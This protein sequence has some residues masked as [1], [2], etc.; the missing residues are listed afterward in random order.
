M[1][2]SVEQIKERLGIAEVLGSYLKLQKAGANYKA[3]CPFHS[4]KTPSFHISPS[5]NS[6]Y[7]FGCGEKGDIFSFVQKF[8]GL[9]FKGALRLLGERA[10]IP[11]VFEREESRGE[12]EKLY[13]LLETAALFFERNLTEESA[14]YLKGRGLSDE[15]IRLWRI[16]YAT[17][18]WRALLFHVRKLGYSDMEIEKAGL[19]KRPDDA[20]GKDIYDRFRGRIMFPIADQ[21]GRVI[22]F[23][24]R[25]FPDD[26][27]AKAS[28]P[29]NEGE[30]AR[31]TAPGEQFRAAKYINSPE[32]EL[33]VKS[34]ILYGFDKAKGHIRKAN[35]SILVEG[36][37]DLVLAHQAGFKNTIALSGT[38]LSGEHLA[39]LSRLSKRMVI[40]LDADSA[41]IASAGKGARIALAE[42]FDIKVAKLP[43]GLDPADAIAK[44]PEIFRGAVR[45]AKHIIDFYLEILK[46]RIDDARK[47]RL[48]VERVVLPFVAQIQSAIDQAHFVARVAEVLSIGEEPVWTEVRKLRT[49]DTS[50]K[51][52][53]PEETSRAQKG[54]RETLAERLFGLL[55]WQENAEKPLIEVEPLRKS[56]EELL[57]D[58]FTFLKDVFEKE[59]ERAVFAAEEFF[60]DADIEA[61]SKELVV[62]LEEENLKEELLAL[63]VSLREAEKKKDE[64]EVLALSKRHND[65]SRK[66]HLLRASS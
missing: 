44:D 25:I 46:G 30:D 45:E 39:S 10:G 63:S 7:C 51:K 14:S 61:A 54:R 56:L 50:A 4:E 66:L 55:F 49:E 58:R 8:E 20:K 31:P 64:A 37:M 40:A 38:A 21:S 12:R 27:G 42:G 32:T 9:D 48:E 18:D 59:R 62:G 57:K 36:Q 23:S 28:S 1:G 24:G 3:L 41:G 33:F 52:E 6:Y 60:G 15:S 65:L 2:T 5:R 35:F 43:S 11:V 34:K 29:L 22:A 26:K 19:A 13:A 16:G 17:P 47:L 53:M